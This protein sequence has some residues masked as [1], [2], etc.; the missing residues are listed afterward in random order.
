M[1]R[2]TLVATL[3]QLKEAGTDVGSVEALL[4]PAALES[5]TADA[6]GSDDDDA[7]E[8]GESEDEEEEEEESDFDDDSDFE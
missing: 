8:D 1:T 4:E 2:K 6:V 5:T 3:R 7:D